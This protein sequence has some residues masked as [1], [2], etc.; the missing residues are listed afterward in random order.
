MVKV[1]RYLHKSEAAVH[2]GLQPFTEKALFM[3]IIFA[4]VAG[5][6]SKGKKLHQITFSRSVPNVS[7]NFF[8]ETWL[9]L[10]NAI[11]FLCYVDF[12]SKMI[13]STLALFWLS[14]HIS[15]ANIVSHLS[16]TVS[17]S[18][19]QFVGLLLIRQVIRSKS[20]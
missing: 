7:E 1:V 13:L 10:L 12:I 14:L 15:R 9:L 18:S 20:S 17:E 6:Q 19:S 16:T 5:L 8:C 2:R 11:Y 4:K 3:S